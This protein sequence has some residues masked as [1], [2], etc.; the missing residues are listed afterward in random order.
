MLDMQTMRGDITPRE[1]FNLIEK[2]AERQYERLFETEFTDKRSK[3][4]GINMALNRLYHAVIAKYPDGVEIKKRSWKISIDPKQVEKLDLSTIQKML[5]VEV[6]EWEDE[7]YPWREGGMEFDGSKAGYY[8]KNSLRTALNLSRHNIF[9]ILGGSF[10]PLW[11]KT[12]AL[13]EVEKELN[14]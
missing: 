4:Q 5:N 11:G 13:E 3:A 10:G 1:C 2:A 8:R 14:I 7:V 6:R 12:R 9:N